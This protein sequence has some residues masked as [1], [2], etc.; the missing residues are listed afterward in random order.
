MAFSSSTNSPATLPSAAPG[1]TNRLFWRWWRKQSPSQQDRYATLGPLV[2]VLLFLAAIIAAFWY[3]RN[4][5]LEREQESVK[6]DTEVVQQQIRLRLI[7]NQE[8]LLRLGREISI[9]AVTPEQFMRQAGDFVRARPE[10]ISVSWVQAD[11]SVKA[12]RTTLSLPLDPSQAMDLDPL[13]G[14]TETYDPLHVAKE[15]QSAFK[16]ARDRGQPI[17]SKPYANQM[18]GRVIQVHVPLMDRSGFIGTVVTEYSLES[19][20]RYL[21]PREVASRHAMGL[22]QAD[23]DMLTSTVGGDSGTSV[24]P[25][26]IYD[27]IVTPVGNGLM[28]RGMGFR[29]S[30]NLIGNTLFWMVVALSALTVWTLMGT[31][32]HMRRRSQIQKTLVQET[33]FR[34]AMENSMLTGMRTIDLEGRITYVN[35]AFCAMTGF[36]EEELIGCVPPYPY[37]PKDRLD[38]FNR[39]FQQ[40]LLGRSPMG[41]IEVVMQRRDASQF[42]AR[43]YVSP[44]IDAQGDQ[45]GWMTSVT[46][47]TEAKRVRD[48]LTAAHERFTTVLEGLDA[49]V[50][51]VSVQRG[52]LLFAN[53][54][55]RLWFGANPDAH[56]QLTG[57]EIMPDEI[58][59]GDE[60]VDHFGGLPT[61]ALTN[62]GSDTREV[63]MESVQKWFDVRARYVQWT[64]GH[65]AQMLI[66]TDISARK[67]AEEAAARQAEK[68]QFTSRLI[69]MGEMASTVAHELNQP[70][71]AISNYCSGMISRV[72]SGNF[73]NEQLVG[74]LEKTSRQAQ[75]AGQI[76][77]RIRQFVK[78][79]EPQRQPSKV[80]DITDAVLELAVFEMKRRRVTLNAT[81]ANRLPILMAD[82]ILIEQVLLNLLKNAA[83]AID[84]SQMP[85]SRRIIDLRVQQKKTEEQGPVVEFSV[86]DGGP[87]MKEEI[88]ARLFEAFH[89]TKAEGLGIGLSLCRSIIESHHGRIKAENIYNEDTV[90]GCRFT[91][92]LPIDSGSDTDFADTVTTPS[93]DLLADN[94]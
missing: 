92:T 23:G 74:A 64:D 32:R 52:E 53:R 56:T 3:L 27:V 44:L 65:L 50:S 5:E 4:E 70:L 58:I 6:R 16:L 67:H 21:V 82:P 91:F 19:L 18:S 62:A 26:F 34:R 81:I 55:Y 49:A 84:S 17:Y 47:I 76:I 42:D 69:T 78:R 72:Q 59:D 79:S 38:E 71:A 11:E 63:L 24:K 43:M 77:H 86:S 87:G 90:V 51:V 28:L 40:E 60:S 73:D 85:Q 29:T 88:L 8:Q 83:E 61:Q 25:T 33:N 57:G 2:S 41:G 37:W 20:L 45:T 31:L 36:S 22:I 12:A 10:V 30:S 68:S 1:Q 93:N 35:P 54:S 39:M 15:P 66:A 46:N 48:Q 7:E 80:R 89:S 94:P 13:G 14:R 9:K 75:R